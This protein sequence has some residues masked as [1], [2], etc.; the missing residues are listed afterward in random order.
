MSM[1][2]RVVLACVAVAAPAAAQTPTL[3]SDPQTISRGW[4]ALAAGRPAEAVTLANGI[5]KRKPRYHAALSLKIEA[6]SSGAQPITAL[7]AYE[8]WLLKAGRKVDDRGLLEPVAAGI[9]RTLATDPD[10]HVRSAALQFLASAGDDSALQALR[11]SSA[12]GNPMA[13]IALVARG[14]AAAIAAAQTLV[15]AGNGRDN[16]A[17]IAALAAHGG[18]PPALLDALI[19]DRVPM[20]RAAAA[21]ALAQSGSATAAQQLDELSRD[22]DPFVRTSVTLARAKSG[23]QQALAEARALLASEVPDVRLLAAEALTTLLPRESEQAVRPLLTDRDGVVRFRAAALVGRVDPAAVQSVLIEG[24]AHENPLIKQ[25]AA[26]VVAE[27]LPGDIVLLR[28]LLRHQDHSIVVSAAGAIVGDLPLPSTVDPGK[29]P[30]AEVYLS[31][32]NLDSGHYTIASS[33]ASRKAKQWAH[34][35]KAHP[36]T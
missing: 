10:P 27:T 13:T 9:L 8:E 26:R 35:L 34:L 24:L 12:D 36:L 32:D 25:E 23:D 18:L 3:A 1:M 2:I 15:G 7:D 14:D 30:I 33:L 28:Q 21:R 16:S 20:N 19:K 11:K 31:V 29:K 6:L 5:L 22:Q 4:A 17:A